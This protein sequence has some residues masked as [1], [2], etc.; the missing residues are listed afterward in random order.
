[1]S[2]VE[3]LTALASHATYAMERTVINYSKGEISGDLNENVNRAVRN[4]L[5]QTE[6]LV[7]SKIL[8]KNM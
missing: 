7:K 2:E 8:C 6:N 5:E 1:M 4:A 3:Q